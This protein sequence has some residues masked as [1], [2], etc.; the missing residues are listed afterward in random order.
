MKA[1]FR[2]DNCGRHVPLEH[3]SCPH[4]GKRFTAVLCP[5]CRFEGDAALFTNGCPKCG[6][7]GGR[8]KS[9]ATAEVRP[10][11]P[12]KA[13]LSARFYLLTSAVLLVVLLVLVFALLQGQ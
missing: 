4:C 9:G 3:E 2:C 12:R 5:V 13:P 10:R 1:R 7:Q 11:K 6:Y 8:A